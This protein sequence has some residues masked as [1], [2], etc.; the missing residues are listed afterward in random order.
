MSGFGVAIMGCFGL[1]ALS[2]IPCGGMGSPHGGRVQL[3]FQLAHLATATWA[4]PP[5]L[6]S[7]GNPLCLARRLLDAPGETSPFPPL[8]SYSHLHSSSGFH[9]RYIPSFTGRGVH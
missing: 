2:P 1:L 6:H 9:Y 5:S 3:D 4:R 8:H 7:L